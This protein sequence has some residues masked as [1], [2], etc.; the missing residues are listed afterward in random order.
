MLM[1]DNEILQFTENPTFQARVATHSR[2]MNT[3]YAYILIERRRHDLRLNGQLQL[4]DFCRHA[5]STDCYY[6]CAEL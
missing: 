5:A 2:R 3:G 6:F 1:V 4:N